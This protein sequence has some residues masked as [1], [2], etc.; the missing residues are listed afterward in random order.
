MNLDDLSL[1]RSFGIE[2]SWSPTVA[3]AELSR[4]IR[5]PRY[6]RL[7]W[8]TAA[9]TSFVGQA[10]DEHN[11]RFTTRDGNLCVER[12]QRWDPDIQRPR[13]PSEPC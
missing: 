2:T 11:F 13:D 8:D 12:N 1:W 6:F 9:M 4:W 3:A 7:L 10:I 5:K